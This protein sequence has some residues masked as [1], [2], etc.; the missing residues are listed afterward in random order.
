M[1]SYA[2]VGALAPPDFMNLFLFP[3]RFTGTV[4]RRS[5]RMHAARPHGTASSRPI[6]R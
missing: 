2:I 5:L 6:I 3:L 1:C 4:G